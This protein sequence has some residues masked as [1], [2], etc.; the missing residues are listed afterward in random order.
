VN[1]DQADEVRS[2]ESKKRSRQE[3]LDAHG[4]NTEIGLGV[5]KL[6]IEEQHQPSPI[7]PTITE[8]NHHN[9]NGDAAQE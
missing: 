3:F 9:E 5:K 7:Q 2:Q 8:E 1:G 4:E 6:K